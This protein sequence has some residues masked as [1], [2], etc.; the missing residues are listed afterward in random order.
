MAVRKVCI[1]LKST[2]QII[3]VF[4]RKKKKFNWAW[5]ITNI[6]NSLSFYSKEL[7]NYGLQ[8]SQENIIIKLLLTKSEIVCKNNLFED[9][10]I[11]IVSYLLKKKR[12][13][14][15]SLDYNNLSK[16][17]L[18]CLT[19]VYFLLKIILFVTI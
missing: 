18:I 16:I 7:L 9:F 11:S 19:T 4:D 13:W 10:I 2:Y 8:L 5:G 1:L 17:S 12:V 6:D 3:G 14:I 15:M